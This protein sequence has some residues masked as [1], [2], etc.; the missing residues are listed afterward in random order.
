MDDLHA[1][2]GDDSILFVRG[3]SRRAAL[4]LTSEAHIIWASEIY[5]CKQAGHLMASD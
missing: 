4:A 2:Q 3:V 5:S 1:F